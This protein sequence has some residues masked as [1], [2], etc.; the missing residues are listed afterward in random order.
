MVLNI[1][2]IEDKVYTKY[3][4]YYYL[5]VFEHNF[6][7]EKCF[8]SIDEA[9]DVNVPGKFSIISQLN[10][11]EYRFRDNK[12]NFIIEYPNENKYNSWNQSLPPYDDIE[13]R[14]VIAAQGFNETE[15]LAPY[16]RLN[17]GGNWSGLVRCDELTNCLLNGIPGFSNWY[18]AIG[19]QCSTVSGYLKNGIP[20]YSDTTKRVRLFASV[21]NVTMSFPYYFK[22]ILCTYSLNS[23]YM[24]YSIPFLQIFVSL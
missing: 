23:F 13:T 5:R 1:Y 2:Y 3:R 6:T 9:L 4:G 12:L 22:K 11:S 16:G 19:L 24:L 21:P 18:Y 8:K 7:T 10:Q 20:A 17:E 15:T 14:G